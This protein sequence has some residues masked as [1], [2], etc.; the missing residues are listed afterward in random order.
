[1]PR[2]R[3]KYAL[4]TCVRWE[5]DHIVEWIEYHKSIGFDHIYLYSNDDDPLPLMSVLLPY[6]AGDEPFVTLAHFP[7]LGNE[8]QQHLIYY[9]FL[10]R[11]KDETEWFSFLD[12]DEYYVLPGQDDIG[13]F[14]AAFEATSDA[15]Y[16]NWLVYGHAGKLTRDRDSVL[17]SHTRRSAQA[18]VHTKVMTRSSIVDL[19]AVRKAYADGNGLPGFWHFWDRYPLGSMRL[20]N[21][22][23]HDMRDY[24]HDFP[25]KALDYVQ[26]QGRTEQM[27]E[28]GYIAHVQFKSEQD[29]KRRVDRGGSHSVHFWAHTLASGAHERYFAWSNAVEDRYL[30]RY[31]LGRMRRAYDVTL[32]EGQIAEGHSNVALRMPTKQSSARPLAHDAARGSHARGRANDGIRT[33]GHGFATE[34]EPDPWWSVDLMD[35]HS[36]SEVRVYGQRGTLLWRPGKS[37]LVIEASTD[38]LSWATLARYPVIV[39]HEPSKAPCVA[40]KLRTPIVGRMVRVSLRG[41]ASLHCDEVEVYGAAVGG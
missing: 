1:M 37:R 11:Y 15:V 32:P 14:M 22:L 17:L 8:V 6:A 5:E 35:L 3:Y 41:E 9:H 39:Q 25:R 24:S 36:L 2:T 10:G 29:F 16:F 18:D 27:L 12:A 33:G 38:G 13:R 31:W 26:A 7:K 21:V 28:R 40:A 4:V 20:V 34:R 30:A 19:D 23:G